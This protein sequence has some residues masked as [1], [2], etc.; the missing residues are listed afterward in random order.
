M[1]AV[2]V[3]VAVVGVLALLG[4]VVHKIDLKRFRASGEL[5]WKRA[6][7]SVEADAAPE[8]EKPLNV[9]PPGAIQ[10]AERPKAL[11]PGGG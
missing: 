7:F 5:S 4:F 11:P 3:L 10:E 6:T 1:V 2:I 9:S 8:A